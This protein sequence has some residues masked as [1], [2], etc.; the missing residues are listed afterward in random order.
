MPQ[1]Q[2]S[3]L[4]WNSALHPFISNPILFWWRLTLSIWR[5]ECEEPWN[6]LFC[7]FGHNPGVFLP[8]K[9]TFNNAVLPWHNPFVLSLPCTTVRKIKNTTY[10]ALAIFS[11]NKHFQKPPLRCL[12]A[13]QD[14]DCPISKRHKNPPVMSISMSQTFWTVFFCSNCWISLE[15][16]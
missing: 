15:C 3:W 2:S 6:A 5:L 10:Y 14:L 11:Q 7:F 13:F 16:N 4:W 9:I 1:L 8:Q 12:L